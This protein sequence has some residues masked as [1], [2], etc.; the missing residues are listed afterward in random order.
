MMK[1]YLFT[2]LAT[3]I[4]LTPMSV[5]ADTYVT[6]GDGQTYSFALLSTIEG[7]GVSEGDG[8]Y[9]VSGTIEISEGD[10]FVMDSG[11]TVRFA[12]DAGL[13]IKGVP[14]LMPEETTTLCA[15]FD[16]TKPNQIEV[17]GG[18]SQVEVSNLHFIVVGLRC[19]N[20]S[21]MNIHDCQFT[22]HAGTQSAALQLG[23]DGAP[24]LVQDCY[25]ANN[26]KA[27][28][29]SAAN[30]FCPIKIEN[31]L[32]Y[33]NSTAN[34][35]IPQLNLTA[36]PMVE[37]TGCTIEGDPNLTMVGGIGV[38]NFYSIEGF[39]VCITNNTIKDNRYGITTMGVMDVVI[40]DNELF[41]NRHEVNAM[42]GG[43]GIS[44]YDPT[45]KQT[46]M[47]RGNHIENSLWGITV[48]GCGD[49]NLGRVDVVASDPSYNPG[50]NV[51]KDNGNSG[52]LYDLYNN[53]TLTIYAQ[54]NQWNVAEQT[55]EQIEGVIF[56]KHDNDALGEVLFMP[57][58]E[59]TL[60]E[61]VRSDVPLKGTFRIDGTWIAGGNTGLQKGL[62]IIDGKKR[63][64]K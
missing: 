54:G 46:A 45:L 5:S 13:I 30:Y 31:C 14:T 17:W 19:Q 20:A 51:F 62:Y 60:L 59:A 33:H 24:F 63:I 57:P 34:G 26:A 56:H 25:F 44:L 21:G 41:D 58:M 1:K 47:L 15:T 2:L 37:V 23:P 28:I 35:N 39:H 49:V 9:M 12:D 4:I 29:A 43:S 42:N 11:V 36:S 53:S 18:D 6:I 3:I 50:G 38:S 27:A 40:A 61:E 7:S 8:C 10:Q 64:V 48:I 16:A 32:F 22:A 52:I 55:E